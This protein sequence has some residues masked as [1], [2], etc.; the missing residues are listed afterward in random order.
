MQQQQEGASPQPGRSRGARW[1]KLAAGVFSLGILALSA[2]VIA[3]TLAA[4]SWADLRAA[5]RMTSMEQF[6]AAGAFAALSFAAWTFYDWLAVRQLGLDVRYRTAALAS[7]CCYSIAN[8]LGFPVVTGGTVRFWIYAQNGV[9]A[10]RVASLIVIASGTYWLGCALVFGVAMLLRAQELVSVDHLQAGVNIAI[11]VGS[12]AALA[13]YVAWVSVAHR[14]MHIKGVTFELPGLWITLGQIAV[15]TI[16]ILCAASV[17]YMLLP[18]GHG[19]QFMTF[20]AIYVAASLL[21]VASNVPGG[22]G[23]FEAT[24]LN[25]LTGP[26]TES[27]LASLLLFRVVYYLIPFVLG[28]ASVGAHEALRHWRALRSAMIKAEEGRNGDAGGA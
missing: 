2:F 20:A 18:V 16:D 13:G 1:L 27:L 28:L 8:T 11:G 15:G 12:L 9:K 21:G 23:P 6:A 25:T 3:K 22:L 5:I 19:A 10:G 26:S 24:L 4:I 14:K 7:F 17:L